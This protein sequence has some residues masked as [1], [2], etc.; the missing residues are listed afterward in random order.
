MDKKFSENIGKTLI[1]NKTHHRVKAG[2]R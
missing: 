2:I 1:I